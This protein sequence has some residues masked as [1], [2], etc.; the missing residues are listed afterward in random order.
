MQQGLVVTYPTHCYFKI[1]SHERIG[2]FFYVEIFQNNS[3]PGIEGG[4]SSE[5]ADE[6]VISPNIG[7]KL[8][9]L[10]F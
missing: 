10:K 8:P 2:L 4:F 1:F 3:V 5:R 6:F 7:T 9:E